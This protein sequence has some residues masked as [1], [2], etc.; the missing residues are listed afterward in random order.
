MI[1]SRVGGEMSTGSDE[2]SI[3]LGEQ[4]EERFK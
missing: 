3:L 4:K 1:K 2:L